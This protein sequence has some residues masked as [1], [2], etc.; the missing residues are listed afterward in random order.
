MITATVTATATVTSLR[1]L[2]N[3]ALPDSGDIPPTFNGRC[4]QVTLLPLAAS[5]ASIA[6]IPTG[7]AALANNSVLLPVGIY[8]DFLSPT[9]NQISIDEIFLVGGGTVGVMILVL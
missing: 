7:G 4:F 8:V 5:T 3:T 6:S 9:G 1:D 2:I